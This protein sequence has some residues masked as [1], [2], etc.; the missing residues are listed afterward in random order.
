[1]H[2]LF[3]GVCKFEISGILYKMIIDL[4]YFSLET[5]NNKIECFNYGTNVIRNIS[6]LVT[7]ETLK[8]NSLKMSASETMCFTRYLSLMIGELVPENSE[9]WHLYVL[10]KKLLIL[11]CKKRF[12]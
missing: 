9:Y 11:F 7:L 8:H 2:D 10:L 5:L 12:V 1:M 4:K 6:P 3:E